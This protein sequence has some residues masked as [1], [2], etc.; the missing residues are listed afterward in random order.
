MRWNFDHL[1]PDERRKSWL[2]IS[3]RGR[4]HFIFVRGVL[5]WGI[6]TF[7]LFTLMQVYVDHNRNYLSPPHLLVGVVSFAAA[8]YGWGAVMWQFFRQRLGK[9]N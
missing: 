8:G 2:K 5:G 3:A 9:G 7:A 6:S 1:T 4:N